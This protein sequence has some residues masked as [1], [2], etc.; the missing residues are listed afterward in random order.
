M[1]ESKEVRR[2]GR[3]PLGRDA[4]NARGSFST[5]PGV[6]KLFRRFADAKDT[7]W[8]R[9]GHGRLS[10]S[11][12]AW[13]IIVLFMKDDPDFKKILRSVR[14]DAKAAD[15]DSVMMTQHWAEALRDLDDWFEVEGIE[16]E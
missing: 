9:A 13:N 16:E 14:R 5:L 10:E 4:R 2:I 1:A 11:Q 12:L 6:K 3:P 7:N 8:F 15:E